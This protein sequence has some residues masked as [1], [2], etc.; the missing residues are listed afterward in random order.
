VWRP[1]ASNAGQV[2][3]GSPHERALARLQDSLSAPP[4]SLLLHSLLSPTRTAAA[5]QPPPPR[6]LAG[7]ACSGHPTAPAEPPS[8]I[9]LR[10]FL[11]H[12]V[13][14]PAR[15]GKASS[16]GHCSPELGTHWSALLH[17]PRSPAPPLASISSASEPPRCLGA[18]TA[19]P[20]PP[21]GQRRARAG[22]S[23]RRVAMVVGELDCELLWPRRLHQRVRLG[24]VVTVVV[25]S[26]PARSREPTAASASSR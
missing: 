11:A 2:A 5:A 12:P 22:E 10:F 25:T 18:R 26:S 23:C 20:A 21:R 19:L 8:S 15:R 7:D 13:L 24:T 17:G 14:A 3:P 16:D 9:Q 4:P 1:H 6:A